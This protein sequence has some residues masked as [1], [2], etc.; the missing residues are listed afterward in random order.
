MLKNEINYLNG[1]CELFYFKFAHCFN[2][3]GK[4]GDQDES[5]TIFASETRSIP[6]I[7]HRNSTFMQPVLFSSISDVKTFGQCVDFMH[8]TVCQVFDDD[9]DSDDESLT[10]NNNNN[11]RNSSFFK[12]K[13]DS[14]PTQRII[15]E[16]LL[17]ELELFRKTYIILHTHLVDCAKQLEKMHRK[18]VK[19][20]LK[21]FNA[22]S[23]ISSS[24]N[25]N[26]DLMV[27]IA[28]ETTING[29]MFAKVWTNILKL[30]TESDTFIAENCA[31]L[32]ASLRLDSADA[33]VYSPRCADFFKLDQKYFQINTKSIL[34]EMNRLPFMNNPFEKLECIKTSVDLLNNELTISSKNR[35][36]DSS[37]AP[38][39]TQLTSDLLIPLIAFILLKSNIN[40][41]KSIVFFI[42]TYQFSMQPDSF[43]SSHTSTVLAELSFFMTTFKAAVQLIETSNI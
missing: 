13:K 37:Q 22:N 11:R 34:K 9:Q 17:S 35:T 26:L 24:S 43:T 15:G 18:Y 3:S 14:R 21:S 20:F 8:D 1:L 36:N 30:H 25:A 2:V 6:S 39:S 16:D 10:N 42:D 31:K 33:T 7:S 27:T 19:K 4:K 23:L 40:C 28:C 12:Q 32:K 41:F 29:V 38:L 5:D